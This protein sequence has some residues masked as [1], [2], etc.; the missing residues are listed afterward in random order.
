M[1]EVR[2]LAAGYGSL[3]VLRNVDLAV[4]R[5][6]WVAVLG[7]VGAG[8]TTLLGAI[9][10][11]VATMEGEV[12]LDGADVRGMPAEGRVHGG[13]ALVPEGRR[14]FAGMSV[15]ENLLAGAHTVR[16]PA[17][18]Q[19]S[20]ARIFDLFPELAARAGQIAGTL[21]GGEQQMCAIGRAMMSEP[22]ILLIDEVS[23]GL[24]PLVVERLF[25]ALSEVR[26]AGTALMIVEQN[27]DL[28]LA[29][30]DRAY[31][32]RD[33]RVALAG[34]ARELRNNPDLDRLFLGH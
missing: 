12:A 5:Q 20:M 2:A 14:L 13:L 27:V 26:R 8:K 33:G 10:G 15:R 29:H 6:E 30:A 31:V 21:S 23:L 16:D 17:R 4:G 19:R 22:R 1:L 9:A 24:A 11:I 18:R 28:A 3:R 7:P 32:L 34:A 25:A